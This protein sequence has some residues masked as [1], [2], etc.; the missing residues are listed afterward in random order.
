[1]RNRRRVPMD[2]NDDADDNQQQP[3]Q[4]CGER[5]SAATDPLID[6]S[7]SELRIQCATVVHRVCGQ[8]P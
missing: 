4:Q 1:M 6:V 3:Q 8:G 5:V 2:D 7:P